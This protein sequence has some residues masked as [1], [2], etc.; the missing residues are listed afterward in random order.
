MYGY[1]DR[2]RDKDVAGVLMFYFKIIVKG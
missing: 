1:E 2:K